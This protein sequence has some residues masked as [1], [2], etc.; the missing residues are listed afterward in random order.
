MAVIQNGTMEN[1]KFG[2]GTVETISQVVADKEL[3]SPAIIIIGE[4]VNERVKLN[5]IFQ[6][7]KEEATTI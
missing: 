4:V 2:F 5:S 6:E 7:F 1:E 3:S